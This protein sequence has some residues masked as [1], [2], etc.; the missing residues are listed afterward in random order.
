M[1]NADAQ[2]CQ[3]IED[4][5]SGKVSDVAFRQISRELTSGASQEAKDAWHSASHYLDDADIRERDSEYASAQLDRLRWHVGILKG[6]RK[7]AAE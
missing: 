4:V 2:I 7:T 3:S 5:I 6:D 1:N